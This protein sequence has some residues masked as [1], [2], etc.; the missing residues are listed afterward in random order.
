[1]MTSPIWKA[2][3]TCQFFLRPQIFLFFGMKEKASG[4]WLKSFAGPSLL[5]TEKTFIFI[6]RCPTNCEAYT[7]VRWMENGT[8]TGLKVSLKRGKILH[9]SET[10]KLFLHNAKWYGNVRIPFIIGFI[11]Y[12]CFPSNRFAFGKQESFPFLWNFSFVILRLAVDTID[13][14]TPD[15]AV[16]KIVAPFNVFEH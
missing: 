9:K 4:Q 2:H 13:I 10:R 7:F 15:P 3:K 1:M 14:G 11:E 5:Y 16:W 8:K 12:R 6:H